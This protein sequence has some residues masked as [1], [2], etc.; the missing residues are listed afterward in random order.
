M[1]IIRLDGVRQDVS[2][3]ADFNSAGKEE[4]KKRKTDDGVSGRSLPAE[5]PSKCVS[6]L[7]IVLTFSTTN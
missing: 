4:Q 2:A 3:V 5:T 1:H 6:C 7:L